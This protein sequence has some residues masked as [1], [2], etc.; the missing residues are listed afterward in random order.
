MTKTKLSRCKGALKGLWF[1]I[2][3]FRRIVLNVIFLVILLV[4]LGVMMHSD[5]PD[6]PEIGALVLKPAGSIV[7]QMASDPMDRIRGEITGSVQQQ[8]L[9]KDL[10]DAVHAAKDDDR[11]KVMLLD[12][13]SMGSAGMTKLEDLKKA[14]LSFKESGKKVIATCDEYG[15]GQYYLA[16]CADEIH[17]HRLGMVILEGFG[18]YRTYYKEGL[19]KLKVDVHVF[20]VGT[21]KSA[22][23]P[24]L[25]NDMSDAAKKANL[26]WL[27]DLWSHYLVDVAH[28]R[29]TTVE[30]LQAYMDNYMANLEAAGGNGA[31]TALDSGL[32]DYVGNRDGIKKRMIELVGEDKETHTFN[33]ISHGKYLA[34]LDEDRF[35]EKAKGDQV[36]VIVAV[37][38]ILNGKQPGGSIGGDSTAALIRKARE[39]EN[40]KAVVLRVDSGGG[41]V[42]PSEVIRREL[43]LTR[44]AGKPVVSSMGTVAASGGYWITMASDEVWASPTTITGSIGIFGMFPNYHRTL[45]DY[46]GVRVDGVGTTPLAGAFR[47]DRELNPKLGRMIQ[48]IVNEGYRDFITKV[49]EARNMS[50]E[51]VDKIAQGRVWSGEDAH[52]LGLVDHMGGLEDAIVSAAKLAKVDKDYQAKYMK[53][54]KTFKEKLMKNLMSGTADVLIEEAGIRNAVPFGTGLTGM[55]LKQAETFHR[56]N[57]PNGMYA[58]FHFEQ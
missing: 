24:F 25:R 30:A 34:A 49:A 9:L 32:V 15:Q 36:A 35:G 39:D 29:G 40:I 45:R 33:H 55:M 18:R 51:D 16:A 17:M 43:E 57:D 6:V 58:Y 38:T 21:F 19:D 22:V 47:P 53:K 4:V 48:M 50:V 12:L 2:D 11:I 44:K 7:E 1:G 46:L 52:R 5:K 31:K 3:V 26:E 28:S 41:G 27:G 54:K 23:E 56:L 10:V 37:G 13:N 20:K 42:L 8:T 14:I